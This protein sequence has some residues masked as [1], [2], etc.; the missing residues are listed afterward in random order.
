MGL[1]AAYS[2]KTALLLSVMFAVYMLTMS[3]VKDATIRRATIMGIYVL[4]LV[5][6]LIDFKRNSEMVNIPAGQY[7][8]VDVEAISVSEPVSMIAFDI[9][10]ILLIAGMIIMTCISIF[11]IILM[12]NISLRAK[13]KIYNGYK[14]K[15]IDDNKIS[16]FCFGGNIYISETD[17]STLH[18]MI[19]RHEMSHI[20]HLHFLDLIMART[21]LILQ[22]WNP[23]SWLLA[24]EL[25]QVHEYQADS[26]VLKSGYGCKEYQ[27]LLL[28]RTVGT[29]KDPF[30]SN[31]FKHSKLKNRLKMLNSEESGKLKRLTSLL[32]IPGAV[33]AVMLLST[34]L[35]SSV[36]RSLSEAFENEDSTEKT[37]VS[38]DKK[39]EQPYV[40]I[41]GEAVDPSILSRIET[42]NIE[43]ISV[44]KNS[45]EHPNGWVAIKLK[46]ETK[47]YH[48]TL[49]YEEPN[50]I[51]SD[52]IKILG[53]GV[54]KR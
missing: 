20:R 2:I 7:H 10:T 51:H 46:P 14:L 37:S 28:R 9:I 19:L 33:I 39:D 8:Q 53:Y 29:L 23:C 45:P 38:P 34:P 6:P 13:T 54:Q 32:L 42:E 18:E 26:D 44:L 48:G 22:W 52:S 21:L 17:C 12:L 1:L 27:Y 49:K 16:P 43:E 31:G 50:Q 24:R 36:T 11:S 40:T 25:Q 4:S 30:V 41:N 5:L 3:R 15:I 35:V 47:I